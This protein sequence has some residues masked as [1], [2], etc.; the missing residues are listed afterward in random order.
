MKMGMIQIYLLI[1]RMTVDV[2]VVNERVIFSKLTKPP[3]TGSIPIGSGALRSV[4]HQ[5][6]SVRMAG[7]IV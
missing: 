6:P 2:L 7:L 1:F 4:N 3:Q 5:M